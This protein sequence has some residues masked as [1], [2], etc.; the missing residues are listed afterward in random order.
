MTGLLGR[1]RRI[2]VGGTVVGCLVVPAVAAAR[3]PHPRSTL[4]VPGTS[5]AGVKIDM[6]KSQ[7]FHQWGATSCSFGRCLWRGPGNP[8]HAEQAT[9]T[10]ADG[11]VVQIDITAGTS[12]TNE[13]FAAGT[14]SK[15]KTA[16]NIDLGSRK[17]A[18][19][20]AYPA[21]KANNSAGVKGFDLQSG[22]HFTRFSSFGVGATPNL[23]RY[24]ELACNGAQKC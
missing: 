16:K 2:V 6:T 8:A 24:I 1:G 4:I 19:K 17:S 10:L 14:L 11:V 15:W 22:I 13:R 5:I 7:V 18:V 23:L 12:G 3:L 21:A 9:V 20:R